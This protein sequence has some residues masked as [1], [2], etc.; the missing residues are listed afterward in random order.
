MHDLVQHSIL[1]YIRLK[2]SSKIRTRQGQF[3]IKLFY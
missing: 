1:H 3:V 2:T